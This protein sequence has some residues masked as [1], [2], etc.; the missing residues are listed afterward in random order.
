M[1]IYLITKKMNINLQLVKNSSLS[2]ESSIITAQHKRFFIDRYCFKLHRVISFG[3]RATKN[4]HYIIFVNIMHVNSILTRHTKSFLL[5]IS[6]FAIISIQFDLFPV[7]SKLFHSWWKYNS[8]LFLFIYWSY[9]PC[10]IK[11]Q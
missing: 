10:W 11:M 4:V 9:I 3:I 7:A 6:Y 8:S 5:F 2:T 1:L